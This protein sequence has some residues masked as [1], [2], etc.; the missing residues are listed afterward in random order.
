MPRGKSTTDHSFR[1]YTRRTRP[2][3]EREESMRRVLLSIPRGKVSTYAKVAAAAGYPGYH[4]QVVQLLNREGDRLHWQRVVGA[5]GVI[6]T[7][8]E[9]EQ[10]QRE[11]LLAEGVTFREGRVDMEQHEH[12]LRPWDLF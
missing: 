5:G 9:H 10:I 3:S 7:R 6:R 4:R 2:S 12:Q 8:G 11:L 1:R